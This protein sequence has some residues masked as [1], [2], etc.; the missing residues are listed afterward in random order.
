MIQMSPYKAEAPDHVVQRVEAQNEAITCGVFSP[1][2]APIWDRYG[3]TRMPM[4]SSMT[5]AEISAMD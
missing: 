2:Q 3:T 1:F 5:N 4:G